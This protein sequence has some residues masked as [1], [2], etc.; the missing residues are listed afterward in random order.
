MEKELQTM[1]R[2]LE[3]DADI[4]IKFRMSQEEREKLETNIEKTKNKII[5]LKQ[6]ASSLDKDDATKN[7]SNGFEGLYKSAKKLAL[8]V[9]SVRTAYS[10]LSRASSAYMSA[11]TETTNKLQA[12]WVG[13]GTIMEPVIKFIVE[14]MRD[15]VVGVLHF[16]SVLTGVDYIAKANANAIKSQADATKDLAKANQKASASFDEMNILQDT[17]SQKNPETE[18]IGNSLFDVNEL[19]QETREAIERVAE[20]LKPVYEML[21]KIVNF[22]IE[23]PGTILAILGG[24]GLLTMLG[25]ILG[26]SGANG[27]GLLGIYSA[28]GLIASFGVITISIV[29]TLQNFQQYMDT[30]DKSNEK[31]KE[32]HENQIQ[33]INDL[34]EESKQ[35]DITEK[36]TR[37]L[38]TEYKHLVNDNLDLAL[39]H[40]EQANS[41]GIADQVM[42]SFT[43][44]SY[45]YQE[46]VAENT[47]EAWNSIEGW[48]ELYK[49]G[50]LNEIQTREYREALEYMN[51]TLNDQDI[52][53][54]LLMEDEEA[55]KEMQKGVSEAMLETYDI[56]KDDL[57]PS[58]EDFGESTKKAKDKLSE[59][60]KKVQKVSGT[61]MEL[62]LT[63]ATDKAKD[64]L[65]R[66][67]S[68]FQTT[69][70]TTFS[71]VG[72]KLPEFPT[73]KL[74]VGGII[75]NPGRGVPLMHNVIGGESGPE[76]VLPLTDEQA[77]ETL[78]QAIGRHVVVNV[79]N[80]TKLGN[81]QIAREQRR[82]NEQSDFAFNR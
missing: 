5:S 17:S 35:T 79:T 82:I 23:N 51:E 28:L 9:L 14:L 53:Y 42:A 75:N 77:M 3:T 19:S 16:M 68:R 56:T 41:L 60:I 50:E 71:A 8:G 10:I 47:K 74:A 37:E 70:T 66:F 61:K 38:S 69:I 29:Y 34:K 67:F 49:Q 44:E 12:N 46:S 31:R 48:R 32:N 22:A 7:M 62:D 27:F 18:G 40:K 59:F 76:G 57:L 58:M 45:K 73:I 20:V 55:Y 1:L 15:A 78:G 64:T 26:V 80:I 30:L 65:T 63:M 21:K 13:L 52:A 24:A 6:A 2:T 4:P 11:D 33:Y 72:L 39:A 36:K 25:K 81:R 43:G 54:Y